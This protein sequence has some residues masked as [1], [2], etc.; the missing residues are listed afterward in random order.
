EISARRSHVRFGATRVSSPRTSSES[1]MLELQQPSLVLDAERAVRADAVGGH[2]SMAGN[3]D[4]EAVPSA[5]GSCRALRVRV[6]GQRRELTVGDRLAPWDRS[7]RI[8]DAALK[9]RAPGQIERQVA[10][11]GLLSAEVAS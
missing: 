6:A 3:E 1:D 11:R 10:E 5:E 4:R 2:Y 9:R 8:D 7:Q